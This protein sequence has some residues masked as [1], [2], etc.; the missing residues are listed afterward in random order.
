[1]HKDTIRLNSSVALFWCNREFLIIY[2]EIIIWQM[3]QNII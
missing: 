3:S 2:L 1:L